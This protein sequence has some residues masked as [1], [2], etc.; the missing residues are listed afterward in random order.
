MAGCVVGTGTPGGGNGVSG[1]G[2]L[3]MTADHMTFPAAIGAVQPP[4]GRRFIEVD[5]T[6]T[7]AGGRSESIAFALFAVQT[8]SGLRV[9]ASAATSQLAH[10]CAADQSLAPGGTTMCSLAFEV[11]TAETATMLVWLDPRTMATSTASLPAPPSTPATLAQAC[12]EAVMLHH[13]T[14]NACESCVQAYCQLGNACTATDTMCITGCD[15]TGNVDCQCADAC[16]LTPS[17]RQQIID[18]MSCE[19]STCSAECS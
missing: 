1:G 14:S 7:N 10:A 13:T 6:L 17:C 3:S 11:P 19:V 18:Y 12:D 2:A 4:S 5:A 8:A 15:Q 9:Q 16:T